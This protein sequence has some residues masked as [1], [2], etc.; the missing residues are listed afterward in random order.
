MSK[1][2]KTVQLD[3]GLTLAEYLATADLGFAMRD[4][5]KDTRVAEE[6]VV[7]PGNH[8]IPLSLVNDWKRAAAQLNEHTQ[9]IYALT[10][11]RLYVANERAMQTDEEGA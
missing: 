3:I 8:Y 2:R 11:H 6:Q 7:L 9:H 4:V 5:L 1:E 10:Q